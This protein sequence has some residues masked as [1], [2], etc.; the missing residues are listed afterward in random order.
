MLADD[1]REH[2]FLFDFP[3][4]SEGY[5]ANTAIVTGRHDSSWR[6][7]LS[8]REIPPPSGNTVTGLERNAPENH[9][10]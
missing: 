6:R 4:A 2:A 9:A 5:L 1:H 10:R 7:E 8:S 3:S